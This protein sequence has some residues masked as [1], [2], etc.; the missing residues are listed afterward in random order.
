MILIILM[1]GI[2]GGIIAIYSAVVLLA[3]IV[4]GIS[5]L[6]LKISG[7]EDNEQA[8]VNITASV[9]AVVVTIIVVSYI[10]SVV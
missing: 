7:K 8:V 9:F 6:I 10:K 1:I 5:G 3:A 2:L 4:G